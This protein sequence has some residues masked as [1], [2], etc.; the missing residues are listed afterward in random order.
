MKRFLT[1]A[2][3][4]AACAVVTSQAQVNG[5]A[6]I[7]ADSPF[8]QISVSTSSQ[9][10]G[11]VSSIRWHDK[12]FINDWDHGRQLQFNSQFFYRYEC[13]NVYE[14][15]SKDDSNLS[16][17]SSR[18]LS[19]TA[20]GN[21]ID[22]TTQMAWYMPFGMP[23]GEGY[24]DQ[25]GDPAFWLPSPTLTGQ[26]PS[27]YTVHKT[28]TIGPRFADGST[29]PNVVEFL[30]DQ[31]IPE[32]VLAGNNEIVA[33]TPYDFS[34]MWAYDIASKEYR[35]I[36]EF[37]GGDE[38]VKVAA[39]ADGQYAIGFYSPEVLQPYMNGSGTNWWYVVPPNPAL[40][41]P[42]GQIDLDYASVHI[43]GF[44]NYDSFNGPGHTFD[45]GYF[46]IGTLEQVRQTL[47]KLH[48][49][50]RFLDPSVFNWREYVS[51]NHLEAS[52]SNQADAEKHWLTEGMNQGL[53]GS[54][55]FS[56]SEYL[57]LNPDVASAPNYQAA[58]DHY[59][60]TG[61]EEGRGTVIKP[62]AGMQH[63]AL[64][65]NR[66]ISVA[67]QNTYA[68]LG[69]GNSDPVFG[70]AHV[71]LDYVTEVASGDYTS[72]AVQK[73]G[74]LWVWGSN[75]YGAR[76]DGTSGD[77]IASPV[78]VPIPAKITTPVRNGR[79]AVA[80]G[81][82]AYAA[83]D[84]QGQVWTW[85]ANWNGRLGDGTT[86]TRYTPA[87]VKKSANPDDYVTAIVSITAA[88]GTMA[89][90][91][92]DGAVWTWGAGTNGTL[93]NGTTQDSSYA[94]QVVQAGPHDEMTPL[95]GV[96]QVACG[97]SG[98]CIALVR[99]GGVFGWGSNDF[100]QLG[101]A[102]GGNS[103]FA[104]WIPVASTGAPVDAIAAG[105]AHCIAHATDGSVY[106]W[107]YNGRGQ[108]GLGFASVAQFPAV[109]MS[110][111][112]DG[113]SNITDISAGANFSVMTRYTDRAVFV[114]GDNQSGQLGAASSGVNQLLPVKS[115][116]SPQ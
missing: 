102:P 23:R 114:A 97:S 54:K 55:T 58:V 34:T 13:Y 20:N 7:S 57:K 14:A 87:R 9:Y 90:V 53:R 32:H 27:D 2:L 60:T 65:S 100:S 17:T 40:T 19:L 18:L 66:S 105:S 62:A 47:A 63:L 38:N 111:G 71:P 86:S 41:L 46:A 94:V 110:S 98:F 85:G 12:E 8:G 4:L 11:A 51:I 74:S 24:G 52:V 95:L 101:I 89:A 76:G 96:T 109:A 75:Q 116:V 112:P 22:S 73:D 29:I 50:F 44:H 107:G 78:Q 31:F 43:G 30:A 70:S 91:D 69:S 88:G 59:T 49:Q 81:T 108:L 80:V 92:A 15:G 28:V 56:P 37:G 36:R 26:Q 68:Q 16:R 93:G 79:H 106:G 42:N 84:T 99:Y 45:R 115:S 35:R 5:N 61:R 72:L 21:T 33:V 6:T 113:M 83:I 3:T 10:A 104:T 77:A 103:S 39:T 1:L 25:C 48:F 82:S 67:G 64:L